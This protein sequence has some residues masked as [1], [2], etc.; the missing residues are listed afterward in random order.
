[1]RTRPPPLVSPSL[2]LAFALLAAAPRPAAAETRRLAIVVGNNAGGPAE[3]PLRYAEE[4][5][6][7]VADVLSQLGDVPADALFLLRGQGRSALADVLRRVTQR[8]T[9]YRLNPADRSVLLFYYSG[10]SDGEALELG[11]DRV[12]FAELRGWLA[13]TRADVRVAVVDGCKSGAL[14]G[15]GGTRAP[16]FEIRLIDQ[17]DASGE[18]MLTSSAADELALES[19]EIRGSFFTHHLVSG[20]RG[21]ADVSGDGRITLAEA[22]QYAFDHTIAATAASGVRQHP[23]YDYRISGKGELVLTEITQPSA[24]LELPEG[25]ER[26]LVLLVRRDQVLAELSGGGARRIA[27]APGEY[28]VRVWKGTQAYAARVTVAAGEARGLGW[29]ELQ[30]VASPQV[31]G[32][33]SA[34]DGGDQDVSGL[35]PEAQVEYLSKYFTVGDRLVLTAN[36]HYASLSTDHVVYQGRYRKEVDEDAF[37]REVGRNDL[38]EAYRSRRATRRGLIVAGGAVVIGSMAYAISS[39]NDT[40]SV[41]PGDPSFAEACVD[42]PSRALKRGVTAGIIG[43]VVGGGLILG[44]AAMNLHPVK[45]DE[46]R[47]LADEYNVSLRRRLATP[48][49]PKPVHDDTTLT[50]Y[51]AP[52]AG[53]TVRGITLGLAF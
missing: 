47:R 6:T 36:N 4:D 43:A 33:G 19:R 18:A 25:F 44:G 8:V 30:P 29:P 11:G 23:G 12:P 2:S 10:H 49:K 52:G 21:A 24:S 7:K 37:F 39:A 1:M 27:L 42:G 16:G 22:Y 35:T 45:P 26:A 53:A 41:P 3:K 31:A 48:A 46:M 28:A 38:A 32:K 34:D 40:C 17:L 13:G 20:L 5:A 15:K 50:F 14:V 51:L 9:D